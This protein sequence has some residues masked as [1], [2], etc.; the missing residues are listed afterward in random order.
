MRRDSRPISDAA[1]PLV[2]FSS[3]AL[4]PGERVAAFREFY[5]RKMMRLDIEPLPGSPFWASFKIRSLPGL[6]VIEASNSSLRVARTPD[7]LADGDDGITFQVT[8]SDGL[9][10]Q[11]NRDVATGPG[12]G[13]ALSN[14]DVGS[15]TYR[16]TT[17]HVCLRV[18]R[19]ALI[20]RLACGEDSFLRPVP[21]QSGALRLLIP[22]LAILNNEEA[23]MTPR[24]QAL[25]V[26]HIYDLLAMALG[27]TI[28][29]AT[30]ARDQGVR[31]ARLLVIKGEIE[32]NLDRPD[33]N[34]TAVA[35][36][37][38]VS[39][40]YVQMLFEESGTTFTAFVR[41]R[42]LLKMYRILADPAFSDQ[43]IAA[44]AF[45]VGFNDASY[46]SRQFRRR[47]GF[48]PADRRAELVT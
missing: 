6:D 13:I 17:A 28:E 40:R 25:V 14:A 24:L 29:A 33:L 35:S 1:P 38:R 18:P 8:P 45:T 22:Y 30:A 2:A 16:H 42:R 48:T 4:P 26:G 44:L 19:L 32:Q 43:K 12:D 34:V 41:D 20:S 10:T 3:D 11:F 15:F 39:P 37:Q 23:V 46:F 36:R 31:A 21:R 9:A 47:F 7:L 5:G 27:A